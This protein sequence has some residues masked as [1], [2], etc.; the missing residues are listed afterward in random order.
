MKIL[1]D[2]QITINKNGTSGPPRKS[3]KATLAI[4]YKNPGKD[5]AELQILHFTR[6]NPSGTKYKVNNNIRRLYTNFIKDGKATIAF[7]DPE[8]DLMLKCDPIQLKGFL[9]TL[10]LGMSSNGY[11]PKIKAVL[12]T[13]AIPDKIVNEVT[14]LTVKKP[15]DFPTKGL[16]KKL[17]TLHMSSVTLSKIPFQV[18]GLQHLKILHVND[19]NIETIPKELGRLELIELN[20]ANNKLSKSKD[21]LWLQNPK[22][23]GSLSFLDLSSNKLEF[24]PVEV[25]NVQ[26]LNTLK[27]NNNQ[28]KKIPFG[29]KRLKELKHFHL[30]SNDLH[31]VPDTLSNMRLAVLDVWGNK[32]LPINEKLQ[33]KKEKN[34]FVP[35]ALWIRAIQMVEKYRLPVKNLPWVLIEI[36]EKAT[37]CFS[38]DKLCLELFIMERGRCSQ[39]TFVDHLVLDRNYTVYSDLAF[40]S[41]KCV[42]STFSSDNNNE[43]GGGLMLMEF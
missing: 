15:S 9:N 38:C 12:G 40:C 20:L 25:I 35:Q 41:S 4:G 33:C 10:K 1:C 16:P 30:S 28:I 29:I 21:W 34:K 5:N 43:G 6:Q 32:F 8:E 11:N 26:H 14:T 27:L 22:L 7:I 2:T 24:F 18:Y 42:N 36:I 31:S 37:K 39:F 3:K 13:T 19:N 17:I 23:S